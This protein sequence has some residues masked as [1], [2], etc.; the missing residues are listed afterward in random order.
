MVI[1]CAQTNPRFRE[2]DY[3][4][5]R[6]RQIVERTDADLIIFPE[7]ALTGYFFRNKEEALPYSR[8]LDSE[9]VEV[10]THLAAFSQKAIILGFLEQDG[11]HLYNSSLAIGANGAIVGHYRKVHRF[12]LEK[13]VFTSGNLGFPVFDVPLRAGKSVRLGMMI[14][15]DWR[16]PEAARSLALK[17]AE[18]IAIP[19]NIVTTT[20]MLHRTLATRAFENKVIV[21]FADRIG[22]EHSGADKL[23]FRGESAIFNYT[24]E[25]IAQAGGLFEEVAIGFVAPERTRNKSFSPLN[26]IF[27][28]RMPDQ[29]QLD[30]IEQ[31]LPLT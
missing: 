12:H 24:G 1:A 26:D 22:T 8:R 17:G 15:Y 9:L 31:S 16:F 14:C 30:T 7:L 20:G 6:M 29:Y 2:I 19:S 27:A 11:E 10:L 21:A 23:I 28:D 5:E 18:V 25:S 4:L 3:N 13:S